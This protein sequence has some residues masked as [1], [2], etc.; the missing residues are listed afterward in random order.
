MQLG[1]KPGEHSCFATPSACFS[2]VLVEMMKLHLSKLIHRK[3]ASNLGRWL[4][5]LQLS[6]VAMSRMDAAT[7]ASLQTFFDLAIN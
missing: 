2:P 5:G 1:S 7:L 3:S 6:F 4:S